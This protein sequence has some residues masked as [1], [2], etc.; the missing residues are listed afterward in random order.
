[1]VACTYILN[2]SGSKCKSMESLK[3]ACATQPEMDT[4]YRLGYI[5]DCLFLKKSEIFFK[6]RRKKGVT[7][8]S[9]KI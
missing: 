7:H 3:L 1:M 8:T 6:R 4:V 9:S 5:Q 2:N